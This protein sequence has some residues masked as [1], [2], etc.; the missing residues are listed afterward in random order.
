MQTSVRLTLWLVGSITVAATAS[1]GV[2]GQCIADSATESLVELRGVRVADPP[3]P[4]VARHYKGIYKVSEEPFLTDRDLSFV[5]T[6]V[7]PGRLRLMLEVSP[8]AIDRFE[9]ANAKLAGHSYLIT[10][11]STPRVIL[12][13]RG[14]VPLGDDRRL[15]LFVEMPTADAERAAEAAER[16]WCGGDAGFEDYVRSSWP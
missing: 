15:Y 8:E 3:H 14:Y 11:Q 10:I 7:E 2:R 9:A 16:R 13:L 1:S 5:G 6:M 4:S 12:P